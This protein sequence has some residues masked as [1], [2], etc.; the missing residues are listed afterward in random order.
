[1]NEWEAGQLLNENVNAPISLDQATKLTKSVRRLGVQGTVVLHFPEGVVAVT[2]EQECLAQGSVQLPAKQI[3]GTVGA[4]D[5]L[6]AGVLLGRHQAMSWPESLKLGVCA[7]AACLTSPTAS[8]G[9]RSWKQCLEL[10]IEFGFKPLA[11]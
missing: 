4:G 10:G 9:L 1:M 11:V 7:A 6:A 8:D 5:A 2:G 3:Q